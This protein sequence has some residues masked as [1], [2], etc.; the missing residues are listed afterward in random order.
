[1]AEELS[2]PSLGRWSANLPISPRRPRKRVRR[3]SPMPSSDPPLF[4][5]D[6]DPSVDNYSRDH[7]K[8]KYRGPWFQQQQDAESSVPPQ[9]RDGTQKGKR[10][11][12]RQYDSGIFLGSDMDD[13]IDGF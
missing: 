6:D 4:S 11:F 12:E 13:T 9:Q 7:Q 5:S 2:L 3:E 10:V 1:M 8:K